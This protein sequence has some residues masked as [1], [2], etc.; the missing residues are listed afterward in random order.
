MPRA[1]YIVTAE[2]VVHATF[3]ISG[4]LQVAGFAWP[5]SVS[6]DD[7]RREFVAAADIK[8]KHGRA[9]AVNTWCETYLSTDDWKRLKLAIRKRRYRKEHHDEQQT[10]TVSKKAHD[11]L[12]K[13]ASR[14]SVTFSEALE[15]YLS[16]ALNASRGRA[17]TRRSRNR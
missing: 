6:H 9:A 4:R 11:L 13:V 10:I 7:A 3:Y 15:H 8:A 16:K 17:P 1:K 14:D 2:D 12:S 5:E